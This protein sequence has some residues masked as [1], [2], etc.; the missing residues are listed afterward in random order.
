[1]PWPTIREH[2]RY[3]SE[4]GQHDSMK[5]RRRGWGLRS[6][7]SVERTRANRTMGIFE[8][9]KK[10]LPAIMSLLH[11]HLMLWVYDLATKGH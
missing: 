2:S 3:S 6:D 5:K 8:W 1:M 9:A 10:F 4:L 7:I 11:G